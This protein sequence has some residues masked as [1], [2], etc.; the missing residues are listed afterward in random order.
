MRRFEGKV[1]VVTGAGG[2]IGEG[3]AK[4]FSAEGASVVIAEINREAGERVAKEIVAGGG[5]AL[6]VQCD[7]ADEDSTKAMAAEAISEFDGVDVLIN[8]AGLFKDMERHSSMDIPVSYWHKF[9]D[10]S[11]TGALLCARAVA[12]SMRE[13]GGGTIV[14]QSSTAAYMGG[15]AYGIAKLAQNGLTFGLAKELGPWGIR[16]NGIAPGP[17]DTEA[18]RQVSGDESW[19]PLVSMSGLGKLATPQDMANVAL[20]LASDDAALVSGVIMTVD[21]AAIFRP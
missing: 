21:G 15:G 7:V 1:A 2:G 16:V 11:L 14:N 18:M 19:K 5:Q 17:T 10:I 13:R 20:F 3:Y 8:N 6:A 12:P 9:F 4:A